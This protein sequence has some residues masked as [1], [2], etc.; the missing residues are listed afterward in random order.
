M[1]L[2][3]CASYDYMKLMVLELQQQLAELEES[4]RLAAST[5]AAP[6]TATLSNGSVSS[7]VEEDGGGGGEPK[8]PP[9][10][11][12]NPFNQLEPK[13]TPKKSWLK[14]HEEYG[15]KIQKDRTIWCQ[16]K[17]DLLGQEGL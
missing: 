16:N 10:Q 4:E 1:K 14:M 8:A 11:R 3:A 5:A 7:P 17:K 6:V 12:A 15:L 13:K 9:R 2:L